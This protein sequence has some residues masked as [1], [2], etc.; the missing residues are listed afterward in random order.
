M[1]LPILSRDMTRE[2]NA[3]MLE[4]SSVVSLSRIG[5]TSKSEMLTLV[6]LVVFVLLTIDKTNVR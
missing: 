5:A 6:I 1:T 3:G 2:L 4:D